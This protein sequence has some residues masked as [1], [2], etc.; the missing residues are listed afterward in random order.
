MK[1]LGILRASGLCLLFSALQ[2]N[3]VSCGIFNI[4][5]KANK[6]PPTGKMSDFVFANPVWH[7]SE[8]ATSFLFLKEFCRQ[9]KAIQL[10]EKVFAEELVDVCGYLGHYLDYSS[11]RFS[12]KFGP[13]SVDRR[14]E[15]R[16]NL[17][18]GKLKVE[19]KFEDYVQWLLKNIPF[20]ITSYMGMVGESVM[21]S[22]EQLEANTDVGPLRFGFV[23]TGGA[24]QEMVNWL[25]GEPYSVPN[26]VGALKG[27][28]EYLK[29]A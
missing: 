11:R 12:P 24:F 29:K 4:L 8:L 1:F 28:L 3:P 9:V 18:E 22:K 23:Y 20:I 5:K 27:L 25:P 6:Q 26:F 10:D 15:I 13:G 16:K 14:N 7:D 2:G 17:Y 19:E 21:L